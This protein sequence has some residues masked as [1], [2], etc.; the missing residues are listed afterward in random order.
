MFQILT[1]HFFSG[2]DQKLKESDQGKEEESADRTF[3]GDFNEICNINNSSGVVLT[4]RET[5]LKDYGD[6][7]P[8]VEASSSDASDDSSF[9][10]QSSSNHI[11]S[12]NEPISNQDTKHDVNEIVANE[13]SMSDSPSLSGSSTNY[14]AENSLPDLIQNS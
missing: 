4:R 6:A 5:Q 8:N 12:Q 3:S 10:N 7:M 1:G 2:F 13:N 11:T 14:S 9:V